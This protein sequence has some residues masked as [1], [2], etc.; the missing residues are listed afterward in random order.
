VVSGHKTL[1]EVIYE[2]PHGL[3][4][5][6]AASGSERLADLGD[7]QRRR[8]I[9]GLGE[10][11]RD[12][13]FLVV[14]TAAGIAK[15]VT[16]FCLA[17]D[18]VWAVTT[19]DGAAMADAYSLIKV[20]MRNG[21]TGRLS[22]VVNLADS[23]V[24]G[25]RIYQQVAKVARQF[26]G[27]TIHY[28]GSLPRDMHMV[29]AARCR[30]PVLTAYPRSPVAVALSAMAASLAQGVPVKAESQPFLRKVVSWL[31]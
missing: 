6:F 10:L 20:L 14:D 12:A 4:V 30:R 27:I 17:A 5:V 18:H 16:G 11:R 23:P 2:G 9:H 7:G 19:P 8:L 3:Q 13:D 15:S 21:F 24:Q 29:A 26:L 22:L 1:D 25:R 28:A 31:C